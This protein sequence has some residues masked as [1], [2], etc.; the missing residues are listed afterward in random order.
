VAKPL[1]ILIGTA[2]ALLQV[3]KLL[4]LV[5]H[6]AHS[7]VVSTEGLPELVPWNLVAVMKIGG[8]V[9]PQSTRRP[10][11][12]LGRIQSLHQHLHE[13]VLCG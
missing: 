7:D 10:M 8:V 12:L 6:E 5:T 11:Q 3:H 9:H 2:W 1:D 4:K 13:L